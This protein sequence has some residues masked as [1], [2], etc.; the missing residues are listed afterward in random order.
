MNQRLD[1][2]FIVVDYLF[3]IALF[4]AISCLFLWLRDIRVYLRTGLAGYRRAARMGV[5]HTA[6]A[7]AGAG[8]ILVFPSADLLGIGIMLLGL[9]LQ[10]QE[11]REKI[12]SPSQPVLER[13]LGKAPIKRND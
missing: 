4:G 7:S 8:E 11:K 5:F 10:G 9:Y 2:R 1:N 3:Y 12:F 6:L 13:L